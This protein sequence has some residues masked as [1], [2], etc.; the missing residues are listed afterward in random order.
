MG[1]IV[2]LLPPSIL[3]RRLINIWC[4]MVSKFTKSSLVILE[5]GFLS[6]NV[7]EV[8]IC[9]RGR[10]LGA[11]SLLISG[12]EHLVVKQ[13]TESSSE[14]KFIVPDMG[15]LDIRLK[16]PIKVSLCRVSL[17]KGRLLPLFGV[18]ELFW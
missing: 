17:K 12:K 6:F 14:R 3:V 2:G 9:T 7:G 8:K 10:G 18:D 11:L 13:T 5:G 1:C 16:P 4:D 15:L